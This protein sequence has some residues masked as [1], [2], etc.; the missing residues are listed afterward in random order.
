M[1]RDEGNWD[2]ANPPRIAHP[3]DAVMEQY[4]LAGLPESD[5]LEFSEHISACSECHCR[6]EA[7][8]FWKNFG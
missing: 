4:L 3:S 5:A 2:D 6:F 7:F 1:K 8:K